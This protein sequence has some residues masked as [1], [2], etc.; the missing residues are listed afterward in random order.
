[1]FRHFEPHSLLIST[2]WLRVLHSFFI[3]HAHYLTNDASR[4]WVALLS[5]FFQFSLNL[6]INFVPKSVCC[7][8]S[9]L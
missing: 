9:A 2:I 4:S 3:L 6:L 7:D 8:Q 1:M 5:E